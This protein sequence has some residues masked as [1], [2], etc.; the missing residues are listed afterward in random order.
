MRIGI[1]VTLLFAA[2]SLAV[3]Y[4][5]PRE[6]A[7]RIHDRLVGVPPQAAVLDQMAGLIAGDPVNGPLLAAEMAMENNGLPRNPF[8]NTT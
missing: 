3:T 1:F 5:G 2:S 8:Y 6:Q 7:K 4:A